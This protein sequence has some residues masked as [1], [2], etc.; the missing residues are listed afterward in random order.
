[1]PM[2]CSRPPLEGEVSRDRPAHAPRAGRRTASPRV[3]RRGARAR[4]R[5]DTSGRAPR[6]WP[7]PAARS[8]RR[9]D[10]HHSLTDRAGR[11]RGAKRRRPPL[12]ALMSPPA[13]CDIPPA[14]APAFRLGWRGAESDRRS[15]LRRGAPPAHRKS[16]MHRAESP[17]C[18][19][20][21]PGRGSVTPR[22]ACHRRSRSVA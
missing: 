11:P 13:A 2:S 19:F 16:E 5:S 14:R 18:G 9:P 4:D 17:R 12:S 20:R 22:T 3:S 10:V 6:R 8:H 7:A 1:M 21:A 15:P